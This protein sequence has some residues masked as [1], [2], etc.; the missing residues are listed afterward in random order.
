MKYFSLLLKQEQEW[1]DQSNPF[2]LSTKF[3][4]QLE[5]IEQGMGEKFGNIFGCLGQSIMGFIIAFNFSWKL[6][7]VILCIFPFILIF[8][9]FM[10][11]YINKRIIKSSKAFEKAGGISEE[12]LYNIKTVSSFA[13]FELEI[14]RYNEKI[15]DNYKI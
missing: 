2:E 13:N 3:Q 11:I 14:K 6:T 12:I 5:H 15:K 1:F 9:Y 7:L 4:T 10:L 8:L